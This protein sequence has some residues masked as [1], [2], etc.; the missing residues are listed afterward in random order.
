MALDRIDRRILMLLQQDG[1]MTNLKL[2]E[3]IPLSPTATLATA[4]SST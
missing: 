3:A 2:A 1:R 4:S